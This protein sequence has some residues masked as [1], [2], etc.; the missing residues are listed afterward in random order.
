MVEIMSVC[1]HGCTLAGLI[2]KLRVEPIKG[3]SR[4]CADELI[5]MISLS[6]KMKI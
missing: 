6:V 1:I 4:G 5:F 3:L 2:K